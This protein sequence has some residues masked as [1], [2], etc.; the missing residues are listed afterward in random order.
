MNEDIR[1]LID[2]RMSEAREALEEATILLQNQKPRGALN[3][4]YYAMFYAVLALLASKQMS[5]SIHT[6]IIALFHREFV[7]TGLIPADVAKSLNIAFDL[8]NKSD[9]RDFVE[10]ESASVED[11]REA[12]SRFIEAITLFLMGT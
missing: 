12:A 4:V 2:Y 8:R 11:L 1:A 6:G 10:P 7:K 3:R 5:A 9:Y